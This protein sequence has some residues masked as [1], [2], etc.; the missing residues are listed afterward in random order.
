MRNSGKTSAIDYEGYIS[1]FDVILVPMVRSL[2]S[3]DWHV[4]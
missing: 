3:Y 4:A 1:S 2:V